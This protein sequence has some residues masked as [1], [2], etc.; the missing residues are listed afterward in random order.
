M[1]WNNLGLSNYKCMKGSAKVYSF[2]ALH[3]HWNNQKSQTYME[4]IMEK[5]VFYCCT[6]LKTNNECNLPYAKKFFPESSGM[7]FHVHHSPAFLSN[8]ERLVLHAQGI[9]SFH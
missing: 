5:S 1:I 3:K 8:A 9:S 4:N 7:K 2:K 6:I